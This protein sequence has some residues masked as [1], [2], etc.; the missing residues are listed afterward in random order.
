MYYVSYVWVPEFV[1]W[2]FQGLLDDSLMLEDVTEMHKRVMGHAPRAT[3]QP[4]THVDYF[5]RPTGNLVFL[6]DGLSGGWHTAF[7]NQLHREH[8]ACRVDGCVV[9]ALPT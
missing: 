5:E 7:V 4:L 9:G 2:I 3:M 1:L 8:F 6:V